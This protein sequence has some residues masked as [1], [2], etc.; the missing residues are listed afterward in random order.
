MVQVFSND[1]EVIR[2][3]EEYLRILSWSSPASGLIFVA[4]SMFQSMGN[5]V[6][7]LITSGVR[8]TVVAVMTL[9]LAPTPGFALRWLWYLSVVSVAV[10][11]TLSLALLRREF[12]RRLRWGSI[13]APTRA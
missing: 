12:D 7:S 13:A 8:I 11:L 10:Q 3:G 1:P 5:T 4:S 2:I 9:I 6:P